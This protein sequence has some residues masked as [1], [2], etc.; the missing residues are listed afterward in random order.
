MTDSVNDTESTPQDAT[1]PL[2]PGTPPLGRAW[3]L[4]KRIDRSLARLFS[5]I[6]RSGFGHLI[7]IAVGVFTVYQLAIDLWDRQAERTE[8]RESRVERAWD[9]LRSPTDGEQSKGTALNV[10]F[11]EGEP[12]TRQSIN[13]EGS[14]G[15][16]D[17]TG[18]CSA[19]PNIF[20]A[21]FTAAI[22]P[23]NAR[24]GT[25][26]TLANNMPRFSQV[27]LTGANMADMA[28]PL[29]IG[30]DMDIQISDLRGT[31]FRAYLDPLAIVGSDLTDAWVLQDQARLIL[32]S[33]VSNLNIVAMPNN[34]GER[35]SFMPADNIEL[36]NWA[37]ADQPPKLTTPPSE[38][39][40]PLDPDFKPEPYVPTGVTF[41]D[42]KRRKE[43]SY[44][45][46]LWPYFGRQ[47]PVFIPGH[48][49]EEVP[50][51]VLP[52]PTNLCGVISL[53]EAAQR[54]PDKYPGTV[55][56]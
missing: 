39:N 16:T 15:W 6:E 44:I 19:R 48:E 2:P 47:R 41:C 3:D 38:W 9:T 1:P 10:L 4:V 28:F 22:L 37:W 43:L 33:N 32:A 26:A 56:K 20:N 55:R 5:G 30:S 25:R 34:K 13:C 49:F 8:R 17:S 12:L 18:T 45:A 21:D 23:T 46:Q 50:P 53:E 24:S 52:L 7:L 14:R 54:W 42:P 27:T 51:A 35:L 40:L 36:G 31:E 11:R 29:P